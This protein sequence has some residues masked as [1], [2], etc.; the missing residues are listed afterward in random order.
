VA[1]LA[2]TLDCETLTTRE[3]NQALRRL[4]GEGT[5]EIV[6]R[7]TA[8]RH[9]LA[10]ALKGDA[11]LTFEGGAGY[12]AGAMLDG[13]RIRIQG[14]CAWGT[15]ENMM[16]GEVVVEGSSGNAT[17]ASIRGG[18]L[19][20]KGHASSRTGISQKGGLIVV[21]GN[22]GY[23]TGFM[24]QKGTMVICGDAGEALGD[25]MYEGTIYVGGTIAELGNDA[26]QQDLEESDR[27]LLD[28]QLARY[29]I[30]GRY[31]FK[32]VVAG[33]KLWNFSKKEMGVWIQ[34]L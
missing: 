16:S 1:A 6:L 25:S 10:V 23:M 29:G 11:Q 22:T 28:A 7:E 17:G 9:N 32:K 13:P 2:T 27:E 15:A 5:E 3:I 33:R 20:V 24:M 14:N 26:V 8:G 12:Y 19:V 30:G 21:G 18:T 34:A 4:L 31:D